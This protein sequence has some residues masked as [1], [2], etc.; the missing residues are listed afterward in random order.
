MP[1]ASLVL[2]IF[3]NISLCC[4]LSKKKWLKISLGLKSKGFGLIMQGITLINFCLHP[5]QR[6]T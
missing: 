1:H 6:K 2:L 5:S 3:I 4:F